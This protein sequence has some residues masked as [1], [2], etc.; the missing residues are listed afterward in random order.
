MKLKELVDINIGL[1][2]DRKK[3]TSLNENT[4]EYKMFSLRAFDTDIYFKENT[5]VMSYGKLIIFL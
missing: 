4:Y 3:A 1:S 2:L 5:N